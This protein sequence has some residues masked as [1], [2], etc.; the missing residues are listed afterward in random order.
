MKEFKNGAWIPSEPQDGERVRIYD[1]AGGYA[2][3]N[4]QPKVKPS[5]VVVTSHNKRAV[6]VVNEDLSITAEFRSSDNELIADFNDSFV[7][8]IGKV[9]GENYTSVLMT[10]EN[11]VCNRSIAFDRA[12]EYEVTKDMINLHLDDELDFD[13]FSIS[14]YS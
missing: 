8:P 12:G 2:E 6:S 1:S 4:Y 7:M 14:V 10:F 11:G 5:K 13:G 9:G 3:M